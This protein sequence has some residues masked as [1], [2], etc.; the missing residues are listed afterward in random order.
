MQKFFPWKLP[1]DDGVT[2]TFCTISSLIFP[3]KEKNREYMPDKF[4]KNSRKTCSHPV[5]IC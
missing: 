2:E 4:P 5:V 3:L 1:V